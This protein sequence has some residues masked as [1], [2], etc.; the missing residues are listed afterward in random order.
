[1]F[2]WES[3]RHFPT[4]ILVEGLF[5]LASLWQAGFRHV[6]LERKGIHDQSQGL[7]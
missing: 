2:A 4:V 7:S 1:L 6:T 3:V 5:D